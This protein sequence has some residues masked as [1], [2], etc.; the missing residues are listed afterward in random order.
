MARQIG[1]IVFVGTIDSVSFYHREGRYYARRKSPLTRKAFF[2]SPRY[3]KARQTATHFALSNRLASLV[4]QKVALDKKSR[5]LFYLLQKRAMALQRTGV[6]PQE[7]LLALGGY[8]T[9]EGLLSL[10][11]VKDLS[12][13]GVPLPQEGCGGS[14]PNGYGA[15]SGVRMRTAGGRWICIK[16]VEELELL[17]GY[18]GVMGQSDAWVGDFFKQRK[19]LACYGGR[20]KR[21]LKK[22]QVGVEGVG[23]PKVREVRFLAGGG[24]A[25]RIEGRMWF[26]GRGDIKG[27]C[28]FEL[29]R[30]SP[31]WTIE[32]ILLIDLFIRS[33]RF[34]ISVFFSSFFF[35]L[36]P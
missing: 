28:C 3:E 15:L 8:L 12:L 14:R 11:E 29:A 4:Y 2:K 13:E 26:L 25:K 36:L 30:G 17:Q 32:E 6:S 20:R 5:A 10:K 1:N 34:L 31:G 16:H 23:L 35:P 24:V 22:A 21:G 27:P 19:R 7:V 18:E 33:E 9:G